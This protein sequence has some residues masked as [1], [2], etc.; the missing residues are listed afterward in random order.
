MAELVRRKPR[1]FGGSDQSGTARSFG[2]KSDGRARRRARGGGTGMD[3]TG[4]SVGGLTAGRACG[5]SFRSLVLSRCTTWNGG[6]L[7][8][9]A[10]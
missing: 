5:V 7:L 10:S 6:K 3:C 4:A 1:R 2:Q 9:K 8:R